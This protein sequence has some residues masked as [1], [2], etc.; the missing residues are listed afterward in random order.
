[1]VTA[2]TD[3][4]DWVFACEPTGVFMRGMQVTD[5]AGG[6]YGEYRCRQRGPRG[7]LQSVF[8]QI[9]CDSTIVRAQH[10]DIFL[11]YGTANF[12]K[13]SDLHHPLLETKRRSLEPDS[14]EYPRDPLY[15]FI[16]GLNDIPGALWVAENWFRGQVIDEHD[17]AV[18]FA[19]RPYSIA[20]SGSGSEQ[21]PQQPLR[22]RIKFWWRKVRSFRL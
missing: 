19:W 9:M 16:V 10:G 2:I 6:V 8:P 3:S 5:E 4:L 13:T 1:M 15:L 20:E 17:D 14:L 12:Y 11:P 7:H 22:L 18:S 21:E